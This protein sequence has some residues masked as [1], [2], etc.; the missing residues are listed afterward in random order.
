MSK[1]S[2]YARDPENTARRPLG[3]FY[4]KR[5]LATQSVVSGRHCATQ[6]RELRPSHAS[7]TLSTL[8]LNNIIEN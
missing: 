2:K 8:R 7:R 4:A 5:H 6:L 1:L 3:R